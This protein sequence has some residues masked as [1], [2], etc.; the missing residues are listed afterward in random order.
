MVSSFKS[1]HRNWEDTVPSERGDEP[2]LGIPERYELTFY[3]QER[4][5]SFLKQGIIKVKLFNGKTWLWFAF[6][7]EKDVAGYISKLIGKRTLLSPVIEKYH[8]SYRVR[9]CF[10]ES[11]TLVSDKDPLSYR[12]LGVDLGINSPASWCVMESD[13]TVRA[14]G[15]ISFPPPTPSEN[16]VFIWGCSNLNQFFCY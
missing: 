10:E 6:R 12:I 15:V 5:F 2:V 8:G 13:G 16:S 7:I 4:D 1:N 11:R 14:R 9:F 3:K